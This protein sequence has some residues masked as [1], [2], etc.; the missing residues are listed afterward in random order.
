MNDSKIKYQVDDEG[1]IKLEGR[2]TKKHKGTTSKRDCQAKKEILTPLL[3]HQSGLTSRELFNICNYEGTYSS[4]TS[5]LTK[6][7]RGGKK[8]KDGR[9]GDEKYRYLEKIGNR[10]AKYSLTEF[11]IVNAQNPFLNRDECIRVYQRKIEHHLGSYLST[12]PHTLADIVSKISGMNLGGTSGGYNDAASSSGAGGRD[13]GDG[14]SSHSIDEEHQKLQDEI[15]KLKNELQDANLIIENQDEIL[16]E[17]RK[18]IVNESHITQSPQPVNKKDSPRSY[19]YDS[20][21]WQYQDK[22]MDVKAHNKLPRQLMEITSMPTGNIADELKN[23]FFRKKVG[24]IILVPQRAVT[25]LENYGFAKRLTAREIEQFT[26]KFKDGY[27]YLA[28]GK[29][30]YRVADI[31]KSKPT[32]QKQP[33]VVINP[34]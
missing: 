15:T 11:G 23:L 27:V 2:G 22:K 24:G 29:S 6:Y 28:S 8:T 33:R 4:F 10:P 1:H 14:S 7:S 25:T 20:V 3:N 17:K 5:H 32:N 21:L 16:K 34:Q 26:M 31:P 19:S 13:I 9:M 12:N 30:D 18:M